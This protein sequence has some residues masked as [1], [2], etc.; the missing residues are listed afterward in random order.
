MKKHSVFLLTLFLAAC[1]AALF[2]SIITLNIIY[3][4][5]EPKI[6]LKSVALENLA[7]ERPEKEVQ[8][9]DFLFFG[10]IM[11]DRH[12]KEIMDKNGGVDYLLEKIAGKEKRFFQGVDV[13]SANLE[14]AVTKNG[15]HYPPAMGIDF[16][17]NPQ[18]V[19]QFK[20]Y[21]FNF[22]NIA[23]NHITDQGQAG[24]AETRDNLQDFDFDYVGCADKQV[25]SCSLNI[26]DKHGVKIAMIGYSM[27]YGSLDEEKILAQIKNVREKADLVVLN[28]HWGVEYEPQARSNIKKLAR[29]MIDVG[30]DII[31]GHHPHVVQGME[32]YKGRPIF[33]SLGNFIFDQYFSKETQEGLAVGVTWQRDGVG[34]A[35]L[36]LSLFP[37]QSYYSQ[38]VLMSGEKKQA[39]FDSFIHI[40][41]LDAVY[42]DSVSSGKIFLSL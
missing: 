41:D 12:V 24:L 9:M 28:M 21:N 33:Y 42:A 38:T 10:D 20:N 30:A 23:N 6:F 4:E 27:V 22:F 40:S 39:F 32:V 26:I 5:A 1:I 16:A 29:D 31:I 11:L 35:K 8:T 3:P 36:D 13:I 34:Q 14:G 7:A 2:L 18:D 37:F 17:F 15:Q 25:D 19:A